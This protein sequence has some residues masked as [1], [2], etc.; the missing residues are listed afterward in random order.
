MN[1]DYYTLIAFR[2]IQELVYHIKGSL[3]VSGLIH[4]AT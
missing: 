1:L 4:Q 2:Y 3:E